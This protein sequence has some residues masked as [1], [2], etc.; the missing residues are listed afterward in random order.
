LSLD[1]DF[2]AAINILNRATAGIAG[3]NAF[4][5]VSKETSLKKEAH[6]FKCG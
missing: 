6:A 1:R 3:S 4:G 5:D 2:N